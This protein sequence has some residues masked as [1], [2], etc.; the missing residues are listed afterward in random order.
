MTFRLKPGAGRS[1]KIRVIILSGYFGFVSLLSSIPAF[2]QQK[3]ENL[4]NT[5]APDIYQQEVIS[6]MH[7]GAFIINKETDFYVTQRGGSNNS[8]TLSPASVPTNNDCVNAS[9]LTVNAPC[10]NGTN[11]EAS[12]Q[13]GEGSACQ[14]SLTKTVWYKFTATAASMFVEV[15]R[16]ASSGCYLSSSVYSGGCLPTTSIAC[17]DAASGPNLN[18]HNLTGLIINNTYLVQVSYS[19]GGLCGLNGNSNTG[20]NF[21][22]RVGTP[23]VC[24]SCVSPCGSI[25]IFPTPPTV[26]Q[27]T[28]TCTAYD[29]K[30]RINAGQSKTQCY[31]F[32]AVASNFGLQMII[33]SVGCGSSGN[34]STFN[35]QLY[36]SNCS[37]A[38]QSGNLSNLDA[39]GLTIGAAY[40]LC[41][42]WTATCRAQYSLPVYGCRLSPSC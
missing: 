23:Q 13:P 19:G 36:P 41:Y 3:P 26:A 35:W 33:N 21:C 31:T 5:I 4:N 12:V 7:D 22:V 15:E 24:T 27:V 9:V 30:A 16:T 38:V 2:S 34:V 8:G 28:A 18:I 14:S 25:C 42:T 32:T 39:T 37:A 6:K 40:V 10:T 29:L 11:K 20:A 17:E 1:L